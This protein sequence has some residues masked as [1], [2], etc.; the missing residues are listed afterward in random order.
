[1]TWA[2]NEGE[3]MTRIES[4]IYQEFGLAICPFHLKIMLHNIFDCNMM[5]GD[6]I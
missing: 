6:G 3:E 5:D 4:S 1:M 2:I